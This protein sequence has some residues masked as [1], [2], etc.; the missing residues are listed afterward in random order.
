MKGTISL[1][2]TSTR[3]CRT[4]ILPALSIHDKTHS[5]SERLASDLQGKEVI[6]VAAQQWSGSHDIGGRECVLAADTLLEVGIDQ[7]EDEWN[8]KV[9]LLTGKLARMAATG[10]LNEESV[11]S[12]H[13]KLELVGIS[14]AIQ[15]CMAIH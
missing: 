2:L 7:E 5:G 3:T 1:L 15:K 13:F 8:R 14:N 12:I 6:P 9:E 10:Y 11:R 4:D